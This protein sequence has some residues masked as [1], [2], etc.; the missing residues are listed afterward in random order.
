MS[1]SSTEL[2]WIDDDALA[3]EE[4]FFAA[5]EKHGEEEENDCSN[6]EGNDERRIFMGALHYC[7]SV[8]TSARGRSVLGLSNELTVILA[9]VDNRELIERSPGTQR[10]WLV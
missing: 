1:D 5:A 3:Q 8:F 10:R 7:L 9:A 2:S 6:E 4:Q